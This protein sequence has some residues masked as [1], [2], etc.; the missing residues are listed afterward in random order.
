ME[1]HRE[2]VLGLAPLLEEVFVGEQEWAHCDLDAGFFEELTGEGLGCGFA[3]FDVAAGEVA[4]AVLSAPAEQ[5]L[6]A[7]YGEATGEELDLFGSL[8]GHLGS[9]PAVWVVGGG[10]AVL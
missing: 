5:D 7:V 9:S 10:G 6:R 3:R 8:F 1:Q 4:V 2:L